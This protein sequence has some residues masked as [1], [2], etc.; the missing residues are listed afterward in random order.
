MYTL[1]PFQPLPDYNDL[2]FEDLLYAL[3]SMTCY[4][5]VTE[6]FVS[7]ASLFLNVYK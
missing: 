2:E 6:V 7:R 3:F 1:S 4:T 5:S